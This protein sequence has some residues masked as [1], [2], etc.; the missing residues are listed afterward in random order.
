M[1][2]KICN[3][4]P[5]GLGLTFLTLVGDGIGYADGEPLDVDATCAVQL[6]V[7]LIN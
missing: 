2:G 1:S 5:C 7:F 3:R 6:Q 4:L